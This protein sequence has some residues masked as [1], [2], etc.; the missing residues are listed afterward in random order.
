VQIEIEPSQ[1]N[2]SLLSAGF[3]EAEVRE[4]CSEFS[5]NDFMIEDEALLDKMLRFGK[6]MYTIIT[7]FE[8]LGIGKSNAVRMLERRQKEKL[9]SLVNIY[10]LEVEKL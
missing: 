6:D 5:K 3:S 1:F 2:R 7:V 8:R 9:G 4:I 10:S